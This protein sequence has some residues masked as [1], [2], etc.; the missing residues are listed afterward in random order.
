MT[1]MMRS[2]LS[3]L[4]TALVIVT[5]SF[6]ARSQNRPPNAR[7]A[8]K[9]MVSHRGHIP[10]V[11]SVAGPAGMETAATFSG[12]PYDVGPSITPT[13]TVPEV[14]EHIAVDP[15]HFNNLVAMIS[16]FSLR[17][18]FN[19]SK[20]AFSNNDGSNWNESFVPLSAGFPATADGHLWQAN[21]DPVVAIDKLGNVYLENLYLQVDSAFN[22]TNDGLYVCV[23]NLQSGPRFTQSG[24]HAIKT[25]LAP[26]TFIEDKPW[27]AVDN[28]TSKSSGTV[29]ASWTH[30]TATSDMI[31]VSHSTD[32]GATWSKP[33]QINPDSQNGA[34][35]GSQV[36]VGPAGEVYV[37]YEVFLGSTGDQGQHFIAEST[38]GGAS[39]GKTVAMTPI[40]NNLSFSAPYRDNTFPALAVSPV[41]GNAFIYDVYTDQPGTNSRTAFVRSTLP[42]ALTSF[43]S[44]ISINDVTTGQ[45]LMPAVAVDS[46]GV[47][48]ISWFDTRGSSGTVTLLDIFATY[49]KDEGS[50]FAPNAQANSSSIHASSRGDFIGDY[51]GIAASPDST[52]SLAHPVWTSDGLGFNGQMQTST[53]TV[54]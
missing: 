16:D 18:G 5:F 32:H 23:A 13:T 2:L 49:T 27:I 9:T 7:T 30:F 50:T 24:C 41:S 40:F 21:S 54:P 33:I 51:A 37:A 46:N 43:T 35:Q 34:V 19:T 52:N 3:L 39:F 25:A 48:N 38:N 47:V 4:V 42:A 45:R 20:F 53:L 22:I 36:A 29:Y 1:R 44:P 28:S 8:F 17:G 6:D 12:S 26:T 10:G 14:E 31:F 11:K 15:S